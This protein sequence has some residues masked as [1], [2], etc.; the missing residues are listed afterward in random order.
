VAEG[1]GEFWEPVS[2]QPS[3]RRWFVLHR[4]ESVTRQLRDADFELVSFSRRSTHRDWLLLR[5]RRR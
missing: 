4:L 3:H 2:Y 1:D 5:A